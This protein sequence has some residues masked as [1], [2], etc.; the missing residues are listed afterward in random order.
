MLR[1]VFPDLD[2]SLATLRANLWIDSPFGR[3]ALRLA[4][5]LS[6]CAFIV[7]QLNWQRGYWMTL[8]AVLVLRPDFTTTLSRGLARIAGTLVGVT[9]ATVL[10]V[11]LPDTP[12][13]SLAF[14]ILFATL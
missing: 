11:A 13:V 4:V 2:E 6:L 12:H 1:N 3:H 14:A 5:V 9:V 7:H 10:V 8:T